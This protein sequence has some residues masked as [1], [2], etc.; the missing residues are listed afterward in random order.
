MEMI[1]IDVLIGVVSFVV[2]AFVGV[3]NVPT[4]DKAI[5]AIKAAEADAQ[6]TLTKITAT[7][8]VAAPL[9]PSTAAV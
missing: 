4:V 7:K 8:A 5:A 3:H 6:T 2:G 9:Q 1:A